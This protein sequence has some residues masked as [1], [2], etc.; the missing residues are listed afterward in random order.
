MKTPTSNQILFLLVGFLLFWQF[1]RPR[2]DFKEPEDSIEV[3]STK[4]TVKLPERSG[5]FEARESLQPVIINNYLR[6]PGATNSQQYAKL[7]ADL[8]KKYNVK[9][10]SVTILKELLE[11]KKEREYVE[12]FEDSAIV[13]TVSSTTQ[14][15]LKSQ[16][17]DYTIKPSLYSYWEKEYTKKIKPV[18]SVYLGGQIQ[19][20]YEDIE[21]SAFQVNLGLQ[22]RK[23]DIFELGVSTDKRINVGYKKKLFSKYNK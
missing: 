1:I 23:G 20:E 22:N 7:I 17:F 9:V 12:K 13:G 16:A 10:D 2:I 21:G 19:A 15:F 18:F 4:V 8:E 6:D 11:A 3:D 5:S 14:G